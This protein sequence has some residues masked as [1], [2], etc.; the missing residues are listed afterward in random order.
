LGKLPE[1]SLPTEPDGAAAIAVI[2]SCRKRDGGAVGF[3]YPRAVRNGSHG[4]RPDR[5]DSTGQTAGVRK[6]AFCS[7][8]IPANAP[9]VARDHGESIALDPTEDE[10]PTLARKRSKD[11]LATV[12]SPSPALCGPKATDSDCQF[13]GPGQNMSLPKKLTLRG[14]SQVQSRSGVWRTRGWVS[15][16]S[17]RN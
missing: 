7:I 14:S 15:C 3:H 1:R 9:G 4:K 11:G 16:G 8:P 12:R 6:E 5:H 10:T 13:P 17:I 2:L